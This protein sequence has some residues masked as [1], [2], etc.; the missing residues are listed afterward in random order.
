MGK[1]FTTKDYL[2]LLSKLYLAEFEINIKL[3][4]AIAPIRPFDGWDQ[5]KPTQSLPWYE[6]YN[7]TK[8]DR[9]SN[10][11]LATLEHCLSAVC[12]NLV[13]FCV[14]F[15]PFPLYQEGG[16]VAALWNQFF[17]VKL[18]ACSPTNSYVRAVNL[19]AASANSLIF[20]DCVRDNVNQPWV[21]AR[22][23]RSDATSGQDQGQAQQC[24]IDA[25][26]NPQSINGNSQLNVTITAPA[27]GF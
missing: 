18:V 22:Y 15:S 2:K 3:Y 9:Q 10:F 27:C 20:F 26:Y 11:S 25:T 5:A 1:D 4:P 23:D 16:T 13:L 19:P 7:L 21:P 8:H 24:S 6:A 12:A 14:R 17:D